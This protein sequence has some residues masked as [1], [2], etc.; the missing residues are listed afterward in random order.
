MGKFSDAY[1]RGRA[2]ALAKYG[3]PPPFFRK[4]FA[5]PPRPAPWRE[6]HEE[7]SD[8]QDAELDPAPPGAGDG[9][10]SDEQIIADLAAQTQALQAENDRLIAEL[11]ALKATKEE[12]DSELVTHVKRE[13]RESHAANAGLRD[14]LATAREGRDVAER[15]CAGLRDDIADL[16]NQGRK[17]PG[18][19]RG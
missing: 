9:V 8:Y 5:S 10:E 15:A 12:A 7:A 1:R 3:P 17:Q 2:E 13:L 19:G 16:E 11:A 18:R 14:E 4:R 6:E